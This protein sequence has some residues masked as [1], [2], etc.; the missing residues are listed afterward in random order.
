[1]LIEGDNSETG[2]NFLLLLLAPLH[3]LLILG[4]FRLEALPGALLDLRVRLPDLRK[5]V[6][7]VGLVRL[8][9][10]GYNVKDDPWPS[11]PSR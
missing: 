8:P 9:Q 6:F 2:E 4:L 10:P 7:V 1:M 11:S 5:T 3:P